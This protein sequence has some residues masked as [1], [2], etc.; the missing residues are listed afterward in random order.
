MKKHFIFIFILFT[1]LISGCQ[2]QI[3]NK[4][5]DNKKKIAIKSITVNG[6]AVKQ[7]SVVDIKTSSADFVIEFNEDY[8]GLAVTLNGEDTVVSGAL[9]VYS[10]TLIDG[11]ND[12]VI[13]AIADNAE[14][15]NFKFK[16][17]Y[18]DSIRGAVA[19]NGIPLIENSVNVLHNDSAKIEIRLEKEYADFAAKINGAKANQNPLDKTLFEY[20]IN[21]LTG[22]TI[23]VKIEMTSSEK[24]KTEINFKL[25]YE[26]ISKIEIWDNDNL[27]WFNIKRTSS[28]SETVFSETVPVMEFTKLKTI[29]KQGTK[30]SS[31]F[32]MKIICEDDS[33]IYAENET[34]TLDNGDYTCL[35][36]KAQN[37]KNNAETKFKLE[38]F[39]ENTPE[40]IETLRI[41][42]IGKTIAK[43]K[44]KNMVKVLNTQK[45][46]TGKKLPYVTGSVTF[47]KDG[48][49][50]DGRELTLYPY[51]IGKYEVT[52]E[53][54]YEVI[55][56]AK[57]N[58][59][60]IIFQGSEGSISPD[61]NNAPAKPPTEAD[62]Y[63]PVVRI[64]WRSA[65]VWCN[66]YS[67]MCGLNCVYYTDSRKT[68]PIRTTNPVQD[69]SDPE[70][71][72]YNV[73][74][75][76][77][78]GSIDNLYVD[79]KAN[80]FR[81]PTEAEWEFAARGGDIN[82]NEWNYKFAGTDDENA[83]AQFAWYKP[84]AN[85]RTNIV[86]LLK[87]NKLGLFD[88]SG[89]VA[90]FCWDWFVAEDLH[91]F[92]FFGPNERP[93][94]EKPEN[95]SRIKRGGDFETE[96]N[97]GDMTTGF[98]LGF[99]PSKGDHATGFRVARTLSE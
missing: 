82:A 77:R 53:L 60:T 48:V 19:I 75:D 7:N 13:K 18:I 42:L 55:S 6:Q 67:E 22:K 45:N 76:D 50:V 62:K 4:E 86:G 98:R 69:P 79:W 1:L 2:N 33:S 26:F 58:G 36:N 99:L 56:W 63:M 16:I 51:A 84:N 31:K 5:T 97:I 88:M 38:L 3:K 57:D 40:P 24:D 87:P 80:G 95:S 12:V 21:G 8:Q 32:K 89:N 11:N 20:T 66:A 94:D 43:A 74:P 17:N 91:Q 70:E 47:Y 10:L 73:I 37:L 64:P 25:K 59:Y 30:D 81:L 15:L 27:E 96:I 54:W 49:F 68:E 9:A 83:L 41:I 39:Y 23:P 85:A 92:D 14:E 90:E 34:F 65:V 71:K 72:K 52:Y 28:S 35:I 29:I 44:H 93:K 61:N 78:P 46:I